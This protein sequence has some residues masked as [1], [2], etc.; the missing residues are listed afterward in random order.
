MSTTTQNSKGLFSVASFAPGTVSGQLYAYCI[1]SRFP[2]KKGLIR[3]T[4]NYN[5]FKEFVESVM[6]VPNFGT[7]YADHYKGQVFVNALSFYINH[8]TGRVPYAGM[9]AALAIAKQ[10]KVKSNSN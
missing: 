7:W 4:V 2:N 3:H 6:L 10:F 5:A 9:L 1:D 8:T